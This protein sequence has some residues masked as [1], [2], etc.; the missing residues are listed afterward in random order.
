MKEGNTKLVQFRL[1]HKLPQQM[2][3]PDKPFIS[4]REGEKERERGREGE[5]EGGKERGREGER[6]G[7]REREGERET[8]YPWTITY[9]NT[10]LTLLNKGS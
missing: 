7:K 1:S 9:S 10:T 3:V 2:T 6:E 8:F 5:R 4:L